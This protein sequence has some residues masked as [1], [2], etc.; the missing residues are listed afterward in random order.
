MYL[1]WNILLAFEITVYLGEGAL[2]QRKK[3]GDRRKIMKTKTNYKELTKNIFSN[4]KEREKEEM[5]LTKHSTASKSSSGNSPS[6][7]K[8]FL[9]QG[10]L[11]KDCHKYL[12]RE[13]Y[14]ICDKCYK[15]RIQKLVRSGGM[16][17]LTHKVQKQLEAE[18]RVF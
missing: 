18:L 1:K 3:E 4:K 11:C 7:R 5:L 15:H 17:V 8:K 2:T 14:S 13:H 9:S 16:R 10:I 12:A 6:L